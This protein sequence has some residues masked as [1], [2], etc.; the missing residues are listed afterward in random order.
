MRSYFTTVRNSLPT[1]VTKTCDNPRCACSSC[2]CDDCKC[3]VATLGE[4]ERRVMDILW[5][6]P[7]REL[8]GRDVF[9]LLPG[10]AYTTVATVLDRL[11]HKA[12]I[13]RR[14]DGRTIRFATTGTQGAHTA[15]MMHDALVTASDPE[16][17]LVSFAETLSRSEAA[18]LRRAL[19]A[20]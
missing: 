7:G 15:G 9:N 11:V 8:T 12:L 18:I 6:A 5:E 1:T 10:Y 3:G 2:T 14:L 20:S 13:S 16:A 4:L 17:A 19:D